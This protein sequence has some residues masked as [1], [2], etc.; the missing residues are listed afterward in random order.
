MGYTTTFYGAFDIF[1]ILNDSHNLYLKKFNET[2]RMKRDAIKTGRLED[3]LRFDVDLP[4][5]IDAEFFVG[6]KESYGQDYDCP[7]LID[8]NEPPSSQP[9][10]WCKWCPSDDGSKLEWDGAEKFY[11][12]DK[13]LIYLI[14]NFFKRW[15]YVLNGKI[16][17]QGEDPDNVGTLIIVNNT[18]TN[19]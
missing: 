14:E 18:L 11:D 19:V 4:V 13:W 1:P 9:G 8:V 6:S 7:S 15:K 10:L 2:R 12:Y 17:W 5:G 3:P 16:S